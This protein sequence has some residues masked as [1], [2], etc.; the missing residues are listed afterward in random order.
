VDRTI[1][2]SPSSLIGWIGI[3]ACVAWLV[4]TKRLPVK[5]E[6]DEGDS[7]IA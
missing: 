5:Q 3:A 6:D 2:G 1:G 7:A 4:L